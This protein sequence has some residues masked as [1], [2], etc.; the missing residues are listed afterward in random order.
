MGI[1]QNKCA[2]DPKAVSEMFLRYSEEADLRLKELSAKVPNNSFYESQHDE[3]TAK[4]YVCNHLHGRDFLRTRGSLIAALNDMRGINVA[5]D[6]YDMERFRR[7][8]RAFVE[9]FVKQLEQ[10]SD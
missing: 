8:Y 10:K 1:D 3:A 6:V 2:W 5:A 4:F 7:C 9:H